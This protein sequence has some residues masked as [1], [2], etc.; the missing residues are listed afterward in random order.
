MNHRL[1]ASL[2]LLKTIILLIIVLNNTSITGGAV[3]GDAEGYANTPSDKVQ[4]FFGV[5]GIIFPSYD[6]GEIASGLYLNIADKAADDMAGFMTQGANRAATINFI[7]DRI[8]LVG[9]IDM[10]KGNI[11]DDPFTD[12]LISINSEAVVRTPKDTR[13]TFF[14][15]DLYGVTDQ[16]FYV[17]HGRFATPSLDCEFVNQDGMAICDCQVHSIRDIAV[18]G[19]P[20]PLRVELENPPPILQS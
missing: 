20:N 16:F 15:M 10:V 6:C 18:A 1:I 4:E 3:I 19:I 17:Q 14:N 2:V 12:S 13:K 11:V 7:L 8:R 5:Q 9:T